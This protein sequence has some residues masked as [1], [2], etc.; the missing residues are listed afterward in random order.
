MRLAIF[1]L[2][3]EIPYDLMLIGTPFTLDYQNVFF[4]LSLGLLC[5]IILDHLINC[6]SKHTTKDIILLVIICAAITAGFSW[7][8]HFIHGDYGWPGVLAIVILYFLRSK[9]VISMIAA[10]AL[11]SLCYGTFEVPCFIAVL[12]I[13][14]YNGQKGHSRLSK[15]FFYAF[16]PAHLFLLW[17]IFEIMIRFWGY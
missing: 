14:L 10:C 2:I 15:Y 7:F 11:L 16:Y 17:V 1:A 13:F 6:L 4:T 3:S 9:P 5:I 12:F 8:D